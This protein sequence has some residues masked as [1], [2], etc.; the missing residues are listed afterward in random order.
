MREPC[1]VCSTAGGI[2]T[3]TRRHALR[4]LHG[5]GCEELAR[6]EGVELS[7]LQN[8]WHEV[9]DA[10]SLEG[11]AQ[12]YDESAARL[13]RRALLESCLVLVKVILLERREEGPQGD[14]HDFFRLQFEGN[15]Q[16]IQRLAYQS[17][18]NIE[19][20]PWPAAELPVYS[21]FRSVTV[22]QH[23][24]ICSECSQL[25]HNSTSQAWQVERSPFQPRVLRT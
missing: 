22:T 24:D 13:L 2:P 9:A 20:R 16:I 15:T 17:T 3:T 6:A 5:T 25:P 7:V 4:C 10:L 12:V 18:L 11:L 14:V 23:A 8:G 1:C 21:V 19:M